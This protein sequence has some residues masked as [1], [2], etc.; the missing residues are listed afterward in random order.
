MSELNFVGIDADS[1]GFQCVLIG[2]SY[3]ESVKQ[4]FSYTNAGLDGF[5][6]WLE[7]HDSPGIVLE[8]QDGYNRPLESFLRAQ[9]LP[10]YSFSAAQIKRSKETHLG[11]H[12]TNDLDAKAAAH[13]ALTLALE[14]QLERFK[15]V[16]FPQNDL[17][18]FTRYYHQVSK[19][20]A[21]ETN[22][23]WKALRL[24][25]MH[26]YQ[27]LRGNYQEPAPIQFITQKGFM[28]L[29]INQP[30]IHQWVRI[31]EERFGQLL[32]NR[33]DA[34]K[35]ALVKV[36]KQLASQTQTLSSTQQTLIKQM[37]EQIRLLSAHKR[38]AI[39]VLTKQY[40]PIPEIKFLMSIPGF[41]PITSADIVAEIID[42]RRFASNDKLASYCGLGRRAHKTGA[43]NQERH[44]SSFNR[45]LKN[46][47]MTVARK[48]VTYNPE[49]HL[50]GYFRNLVKQGMK[51]TEARKRVARALVRSVFRSLM[52]IKAEQWREAESAANGNQPKGHSPSSATFHSPA[53][54]S[55]TLQKQK[56]SRNKKKAMP[57][58]FT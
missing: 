2:R 35:Q 54:Q 3:P 43:T 38:E 55:M 8:G 13:Q 40:G 33:A 42:I 24:N 18:D 27:W 45:R 47:F 7:N 53:H 5:R 34:K 21:Q 11:S 22:R 48:Y 56:S 1:G 41:G 49:S 44:F 9:Q 28:E 20:L 29:L 17:R 31:P 36:L 32:S 19:Q 25:A 37:A 39:S 58:V 46:A 57:S 6:K 26:L 16:Y 12:K 15:R 4:Y 23:L 52:A 50:A 10:F 30:D 51:P 14:N